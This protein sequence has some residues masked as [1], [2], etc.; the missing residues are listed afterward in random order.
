MIRTY[1]FSGPKALLTLLGFLLVALI[2]LLILLPFALAVFILAGI[3]AFLL[4][5]AS[6]LAQIFR[7]K[8]RPRNIWAT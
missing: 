2:V 4:G 3:I 5:L 7:K 8:P 1:R 6:W